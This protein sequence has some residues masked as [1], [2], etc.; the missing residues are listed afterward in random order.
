MTNLLQDTFS[1]Y[2]LAGYWWS[3][4]KDKI[5]HLFKPNSTFENVIE[6]Y[7]FDR[8][9]RT[10]LFDVIERIEIGFRTK[11]I[12]HLSTEIGPNWFE[13]SVN[14]IDTSQHTKFLIAID[15]ELLRSKEAFIIEHNKKH[16]KDT[17]RPPA[18][19]TLEVISFGTMSMLYGNLKPSIKSKKKIARDLNAINHEYLQSWLQSITQIRNICAHHGRLWNKNLPGRLKVLPN[20]PGKWITNIPIVNEPIMNEHKMLY[21][22][23]CTMKYLLDVIN[24]NN[25]FGK[26]LKNLLIKYPNIDPNALGLKP[27]WEN[28]QLWI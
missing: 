26:K 10:L 3:M 28:E 2:R 15:N 6:I 5:N 8:E 14:F 24:P 1:Y 4:Q 19:K 20:P 18:W 27:N 12:N 25:T 9:L 16:P 23:L 11:L 21:I 13:D 17:L 7:N 22:H